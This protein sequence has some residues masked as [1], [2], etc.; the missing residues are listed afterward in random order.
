MRVQLFVTCLVDQLRPSVGEAS[1]QVLETAGCTVE[2]DH[3]Q[4]CCGQ[5][6]FNAGHHDEARAVVARTVQLLAAWLDTGGQA[7]VC[8]SG[9]CTA[10]IKHAPDLLGEDHPSHADAERVALHTH[11]FSSFLIDTIGISDLGARW[12]GKV[13]WHDACHGLRELGIKSQPRELLDAIT[14]VERIE[15]SNCERCCGFGGTFSVTSPAISG[16]MAQDKV[17]A[18]EASNADVVV[19]GDVSCLM[20]LQ[21]RLEEQGS[22][23]RVLHLAQ[24]LAKKDRAL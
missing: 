21:G 16:A 6:A 11:E 13:T 9:S 7:I 5:P 23:V 4:T 3:N 19:A 20:Q 8:P 1:M 18:I 2:F 17:E 14:G 15:C 12:H 10:M 24:L 22:T